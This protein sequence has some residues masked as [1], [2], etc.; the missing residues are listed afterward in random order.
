MR[1]LRTLGL[2]LE[3]HH[4]SALRVAEWLSGRPQVKRV[5]YPALPGD[6]GHA[7]WKRDFRGASGLLA[8]VMDGVPKAGVDAFLNSLELFGMGASFGGFESL[9]IPMDP[10]RHRS[11][12]RWPADGP[13]VRLHVGLEDV[14]DLIEDL[15]R[16]LAQMRA[17]GAG[18]R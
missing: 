15:E 16:G 18:A 4:R 17:V 8:I 14:D 12:T 1:G 5:L 6:P 11:A 13:Y 10:A 2:R 3:R 7:L 9:A